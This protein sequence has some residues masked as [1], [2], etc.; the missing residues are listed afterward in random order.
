MNI[1]LTCAGR[2]NYLVNYFKQILHG[3]GKV[4]ATDTQFTAPA[5]VDADI[6]VQVPSVTDPEYIKSL[7]RICSEYSI[8]AIV[9]LNDLELPI[10]SYNKSLF[11][12]IGATVIVSDT[13]VIDTCFDKWKTQLFL[14]KL[15]INTP[16]TY[17]SVAEVT[18]ALLH[19]EV[20]FPLIIKPRW[21]SASIG[22]EVV[23]SLEELELTYRL[24]SMRLK[25]TILAEVSSDSQAILI[26][27]KLIGQEF[28]MDVLNDLNGDFVGCFAKKKLGMRDG[29]TDKAQL[30]VDERFGQIGAQ[31]GSALN[32]IGNLDMDL[33]D[34]GSGLYVLE[35]NP[36]FGG[37]YPFTHE[38]GVNIPA[39]LMQ[40][41][42]GNT[43]VSQYLNFSPGL[44][45]AKC[46]RIVEVYTEHFVEK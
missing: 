1:L 7:I 23:E 28:G 15:G 27:E 10:I 39:I 26:Q 24:L 19:G 3:S 11:A 17:L 6:A 21:G 38:G 5:L 45:F 43:D 31:I 18:E 37:G 36:R 2:R 25:R 30:I 20:S 40:W 14:T 42:K 34:T 46:D 8:D 12:E 29:E 35:L 22:V 33:F 44:A 9:S 16:K 32:H 13:A 4:V 41:L